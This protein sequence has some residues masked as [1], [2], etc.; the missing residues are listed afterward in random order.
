MDLV[1][2]FYWLEFSS[3][4][5]D[6]MAKEVW[7]TD[8]NSAEDASFDVAYYRGKRDA[9]RIAASKLKDVDWSAPLS[10][11]GAKEIHFQENQ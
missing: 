9:Y 6:Q 3:K 1:E 4:G 2:L 7:N 8:F 5:A 10:T 11:Q